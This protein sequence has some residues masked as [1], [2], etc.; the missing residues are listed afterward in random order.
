MNHDRHAPQVI[1]ERAHS[2]TLTVPR[3]HSAGTRVLS[4]RRNSRKQ[5]HSVARRRLKATR[6]ANSRFSNCAST[7]RISAFHDEVLGGDV[8]PMDVLKERIQDWVAL[9]KSHSASSEAN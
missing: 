1:T 4:S 5:L 6:L 9:Q 7:P 3:S 2:C 8:L